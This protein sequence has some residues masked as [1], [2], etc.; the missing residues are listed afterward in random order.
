MS[1]ILHPNASDRK[2]S[3]VALIK[4]LLS[5]TDDEVLDVHLNEL[6]TVLLWKLTE[7]ESLH[8]H[9]TRYQ[10]EEALQCKDPGELR[11]EHVFQRGKMIAELKAARSETEIEA[12]LAKAAGCTVTIHEHSI[13][14]Q[15]ESEYGWERYR[16]ASVAVI[17]TASGERLTF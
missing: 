3:A 2:A 4:R 14:A 11:H 10:S 9:K 1:F 15:F 8:K 13:L 17:D 16:K 12:I 6:L 7:A 5:I